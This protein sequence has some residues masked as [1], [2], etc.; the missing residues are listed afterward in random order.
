M[1]WL[2]VMLAML[3]AAPANAATYT[4]FETPEWIDASR[5]NYLTLAKITPGDFGTEVIPTDYCCGYWTYFPAVISFD[6]TPDEDAKFAFSLP[7]GD[8]LL[9]GQSYSWT[10]PHPVHEIWIAIRLQ[11]P[12][13]KPV[14][15]QISNLVVDYG[16]ASWVPEPATWAMMIVGFGMVGGMLRHR[17]G[18]RAQTVRRASALSA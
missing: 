1:R 11:D 14:S 18:S 13:G 12:F 8:Q 16:Y 17:A 3:I 9:A 15:F 5:G 7:I 6:I 2:L 4:Y 10:N